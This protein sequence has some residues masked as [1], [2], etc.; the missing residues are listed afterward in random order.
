MFGGGGRPEEA[1]VAPSPP[2]PEGGPRQALGV[3]RSHAHVV[4]E[5]EAPGRARAGVVPGGAQHGQG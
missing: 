2:V 3:A 1:P 5:A 4:E